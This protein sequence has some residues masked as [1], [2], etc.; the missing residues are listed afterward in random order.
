MEQRRL[1]LGGGVPG[2]SEKENVFDKA[3]LLP[4]LYQSYFKSLDLLSPL[5]DP[6]PQRTTRRRRL[7]SR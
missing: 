3:G 6:S 1:R 2:A 7:L 5:Y 4:W